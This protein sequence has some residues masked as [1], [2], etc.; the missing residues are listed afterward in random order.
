MKKTATFLTLLFT[1]VS[2]AQ[3]TLTLSDITYTLDGTNLTITDYT[4]TTEKDIIIPTSFVNGASTYDV[5][6]IGNQAFDS[7]S[8]TSVSIPDSVTSIGDYAFSYNSNL[9]SINIPNNVTSIGSY[10]FSFISATSITIPD[11]VT[12]IGSNAFFHWEQKI[13]EITYLNANPA[14]YPTSMVS[15]PSTID[16]IIPAGSQTAF[17]TAGWTLSL[18]HI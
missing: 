16:L 12:S 8:L 17:T 7:N 1:I 10:A 5:T 18:I 6:S 3:Y 2:F 13:T 4:N 15:S 14:S 9:T 11:S